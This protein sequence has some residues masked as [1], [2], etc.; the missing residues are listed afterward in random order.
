MKAF[1]PLMHAFG[2]C[3][4]LFLAATT[5]A[6]AVGAIIYTDHSKAIPSDAIH[7]DPSVSATHA[8]HV[9]GLIDAA[10]EGQVFVFKAGIHFLGELKPKH[11]Q[12][13]YGQVVNGQ[14]ATILTGAKTIAPGSFTYDTANQ[15]YRLTGQTQPDKMTAVMP[16][17]NGKPTPMTMKPHERVSFRYDVLK[18]NKFLRHATVGADWTDHTPREVARLGPESFFFDYGSDTIYLKDNPGG[19]NTTIEVMHYECA[20]WCGDDVADRNKANGVT[21]RNLIFEKYATFIN[22]GAVRAQGNNWVIEDN[23]F[24]KNHGVGISCGVIKAYAPR[25]YPDKMPAD[26]ANYP[27]GTIIRHNYVHDNGGAPARKEPPP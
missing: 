13:F 9:R 12:Q 16:G 25:R 21:F 22:H 17:A 5:N 26:I 7:V 18:N 1:N 19:T 24:R 8:K 15:V 4:G 6:R 10:P 23:E 27:A 11:N 20:F 2:I 14:L 3:L